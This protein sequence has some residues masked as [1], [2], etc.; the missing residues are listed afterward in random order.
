MLEG[1]QDMRQAERV[2]LS[3]LETRPSAI[4]AA[5]GYVMLSTTYL[6]LGR[7]K[8]ALNAIN[9]GLQLNP[10]DGMLHFILSTVYFTALCYEKAPDSAPPQLPI[11]TLDILDCTSE[12]AYRIVEE[13][14]NLAIRLSGE[15]KEL[16]KAA[17]DQLATV[18]FLK[19]M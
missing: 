2:L 4:E 8:D 6:S 15:D 12:E 1:I 9:T 5:V 18:R 10:D 16:V 7:F 17:R 13:H 19:S 14:A 11:C 3:W